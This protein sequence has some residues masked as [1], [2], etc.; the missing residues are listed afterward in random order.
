[1]GNV[2][3]DL[4]NGILVHHFSCLPAVF[5]SR[6]EDYCALVIQSW[7]HQVCEERRNIR[8]PSVRPPTMAESYLSFGGRTT[9]RSYDQLTRPKAAKIIQRAWR[10]HVVRVFC[11][12][13]EFPNATYKTECQGWEKNWT[14]RPFSPRKKFQVTSEKHF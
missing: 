13:H 10:R 4:T 5:Y 9:R 14:I 11:H 7:W 8:I 12:F 1:M 6:F 3:L 2:G